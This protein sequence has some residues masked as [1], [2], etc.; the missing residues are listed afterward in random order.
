MSLDAMF[1]AGLKDELSRALEGARIDKIH[2]PERDEIVLAVRGAKAPGRLLISANPG[3]ARVCGLDGMRENPP[4]A[5]MFCMLLRKHLT[6]GRIR[7]VYQPG[8]ERIL[9]SR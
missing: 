6:G 3:K 4:N 9:T 2:Q 5:P 7:R 8:L 1:V